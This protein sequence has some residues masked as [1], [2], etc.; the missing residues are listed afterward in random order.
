VTETYSVL[1]D[2]RRL[3]VVV[4]AENWRMRQPITTRRVYD[5]ATGM[6]ADECR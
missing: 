2:P 4:K 5:A 6:G 1:S 3:Q